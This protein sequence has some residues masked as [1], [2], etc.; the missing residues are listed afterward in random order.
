M[1]A[2]TST[3]GGDARLLDRLEHAPVAALDRLARA[4]ESYFE[5]PLR[6]TSAAVDRIGE[7]AATAAGEHRA[8]HA[9]VNR[10]SPMAKAFVL[11]G[12]FMV[13]LVVWIAVEDGGGQDAWLTDPGAAAVVTG[14]GSPAATSGGATANTANTSDNDTAGGGGAAAAGAAMPGMAAGMA[15]MAGM[16]SPGTASPGTASPGSTASPA[17]TGAP[18]A[19]AGAPAA[20]ATAPASAATAVSLEIQTGATD[21]RPGWPR[22][23]P[24]DV[25]VRAGVPVTLT[26]VNHDDGTAPLPASLAIYDAVQGGTETVNGTS[27]TSVPNANVAH[28]WTVPALGLNVVVPAAPTGG[29]DTVTFTFTPRKTGTFSW[30]CYAPCGTGSSG[31]GGPMTTDGWMRGTLTVS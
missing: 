7:R 2:P 9:P 24:A 17:A 20:S 23:V 5:H 11:C 30:Q 15:G 4:A 29:T 3:R 13:G 22:F 19:A 12:A 18:P 16:A 6:G 21:G 8:K 31:M 26:I 25:T 1:T 10:L 14:G 27:V 28:T